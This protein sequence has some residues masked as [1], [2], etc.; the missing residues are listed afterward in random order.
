MA[1]R[2]EGEIYRPRKDLPPFLLETV[3]GQLMIAPSYANEGARLGPYDL[4][5]D[6]GTSRE[7]LRRPVS[8]DEEIKSDTEDFSVLSFRQPRIRKALE[9]ITDL[10]NKPGNPENVEDRYIYRENLREVYWA[11]AEAVADW[12]DTDDVLVLSPKNGGI[13][14]QEVFEQAGIPRDSFFDYRLSRVQKREDH[15]LMVGA[16]VAKENPDVKKY[17]KI[18][19]ADDCLASDI[20]IASTI[21]LLK[22]MGVSPEETELMV[23]VSV[24]SQRGLESLVSPEAKKAFG[25]K[26]M[27]VVVGDI[28]PGLNEHFYLLRRDGRAFVGDMGEYTKALPPSS[29]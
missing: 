5:V 29:Q 27:K 24:A 21:Q 18:V 25:F 7:A 10:V 20:S 2:I 19:I 12:V 6:F 23:T 3:D 26:S 11:M 4:V 22:Q 9:R 28:A 1:S 8:E 14:V 13:F 15:G 17:K 16:T